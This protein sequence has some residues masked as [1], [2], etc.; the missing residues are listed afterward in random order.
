MNTY[1]LNNIDLGS[2]GFI[3]GKQNESNIALTG[4]FDMPARI[5]K[6]FHSWGDEHSI[7]P[8]VSA[9]EI[10]FGGRS[11]SLNGYIYGSGK[12]DC[13]NKAKS[14]FKQIDGFTDLVPLTCKWGTYQVYVNE[15]VLGNFLGDHALKISFSFRE[16]IVEMNGVLPVANGASYGIDGIS[17]K[18]LGGVLVSS[19]GRQFNRAAP[20]SQTV[21][22]WGKE[23]YAVTKT[24]TN[25][26]NL[27]IFIDQSG[28]IDF[29]NKISS[30][31][32]LFAAP[33]MRVFVPERGTPFSFFVKDGFKVTNVFSQANRMTGMLECKITGGNVEA[34]APLPPIVNAGNDY[35]LD[36]AINQILITS[37]SVTPRSGALIVSVLWELAYTEPSGLP[38]SILNGDTLFPLAKGIDHRGVYH[39]KLTAR[40]SNGNSSEAFMK[41]ISRDQPINNVFPFTF[42]YN[43]L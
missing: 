3:A 15:P 9:S 25:E 5:G 37:A 22:V 21:S 6:T 31:S 4:C 23:G 26:L 18:E 2:F 24:E 14:L 20:K 7:E 12:T 34:L 29:K 19:N 27:K 1:K 32:A 10:Q 13:Q 35:T 39:L 42:S 36:S 33:G 43:L 11:I 41:I 40:D 8:Y 17:F 28:L 16:P 30:L 38:L